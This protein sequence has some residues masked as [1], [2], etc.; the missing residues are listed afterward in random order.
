MIYLSLYDG[1]FCV[2]FER[3]EAFKAFLEGRHGKF[4]I[5][6]NPEQQEGLQQWMKETYSCLS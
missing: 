5:I 3:N 1:F 4:I 6:Q 2:S